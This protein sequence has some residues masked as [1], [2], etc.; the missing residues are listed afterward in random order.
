MR[1]AAILVAAG[2]LL[3]S[4]LV[5]PALAAQSAPPAA[6]QTAADPE[7][8]EERPVPVLVSGEPILWISTGIGPYSAQLRADRIQARLRDII[9]DRTLRDATVTVGEVDG[10]SELRVGPK[11]VLVVAP[12]D[13]AKLN[14]PRATLAEQYARVVEEAIR[15]DRLRHAPATLLR[16][17][18]YGLVATLIFAALVW[19]ILRFTR[20][21]HRRLAARISRRSE[22]FRA[23]QVE[24]LGDARVGGTLRA[25]IS[26]LRAL[27]LLAAF[28]LYLTYVLGL[29]PWTRAVSLRL[30][31]YV[32]TPVRALALAVAGYL[33]K[34]LFV[35]VI[36]VAVHIAI[37]LVGIFFRQIQAGR[38][39]FASFPAEWADP[40]N[41][42]VRVLIIALGLVVAFP[43]LPASDSPAFAGV[44]V[45]MGVLVSLASS[46]ALSNMMAGLVLTY[47]GAFRHG[48]RV[49]VGEAFGDIIETSLLVTRIRTIK[50]EDITIPN[51]L[52]LGT[53]VTNY[54]REATTRGLILHTTITIGYDAPWRKIHELLVE[55][56]L[57]TPDILREPRPFVWQTSLNDFYVSYEIN[58]YTASPAAMLDTYA[59]LHASIQDAFFAAGV[60]IMSPHYTSVRD[61]NTAAIPE[62]FRGPGYQAPA[63]RIDNGGPGRVTSEVR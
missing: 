20:A 59:A 28:N 19:L 47:T 60:E 41:K 43:Y 46:S 14:V 7:V 5:R 55:A 40:T 31:D 52:V 9:G 1:I 18:G 24:L 6:A 23:L 32:F 56:A 15:V 53:T 63:F 33:P 30:G 10:A 49:K 13:A 36:G 44:S 29:F 4:G 12:Q 48:D 54:T 2:C 21:L 22:A 17:A 61:G 34:L 42:I 39:V 27:L 38:V 35:V 51:S 8:T 3:G 57:A 25:V 62:A 26:V 16:S 11:L 37:R 58:A 50:N 45:F